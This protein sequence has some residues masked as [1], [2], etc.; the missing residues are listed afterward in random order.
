MD[1]RVDQPR[2]QH[3]VVTEVEDAVAGQRGTAGFDR[4]D[5]A[6]VDAD[7]HRDFTLGRHGPGGAHHKIHPK[8][9]VGRKNTADFTDRKD[10]FAQRQ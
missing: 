2:Q 1:V 4:D 8:P 9:F 7:G 6:A 5:P 10:G 3:D